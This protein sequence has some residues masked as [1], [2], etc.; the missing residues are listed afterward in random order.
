M[1]VCRAVYRSSLRYPS[2]VSLSL[3]V[4]RLPFLRRSAPPQDPAL[5]GRCHHLA[6]NALSLALPGGWWCGAESQ[7]SAIR[8]HCGTGRAGSRAHLP[9]YFVVSVLPYTISRWHCSREIAGPPMSLD[10]LLRC[11]NVVDIILRE[12]GRAET[13]S[14]WRRKEW[15]AMTTTTTAPI[16]L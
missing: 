5:S 15:A 1:I 16:Q 3:S 14:N 7:A 13:L 2:L 12:R 6:R 4:S 9:R 8:A 10:L 11:N